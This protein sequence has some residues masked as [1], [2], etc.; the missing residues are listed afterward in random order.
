MA[1]KEKYIQRIGQLIEEAQEMIIFSK[2]PPPNVAA[3]FRIID[4]TNFSKWRNSTWNLII[5]ITGEDSHYVKSFLEQV[6]VEYSDQV[7]IGIGILKSLK[8]ELELGFLHLHENSSKSKQLDVLP[9]TE[10]FSATQAQKN[11][12]FVV[13]GHNE[14]ILFKTKDFLKKLQLEPVILRELPNEGRTI[15]EKFMEYSTQAG[16][17]IVLLTPDDRGGSKSDSYEDQKFRARQNV[18]LELGFFLG[19]LG[20]KRV[21]VLYQ[22][23]LEIPSDY[24]GVLF[25]EV[26]KTDGW[27]I[28]LAREIKKAGLNVDMNLL[29]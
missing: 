3:S 5:Q 17:A 13:H 24:Q 10:T 4:K 7:D 2:S 6:I 8:E 23:H 12:V 22:K 25:V 15:I 16:F 9:V 19:S 21:C 29:A 18:I 14:E 20:R 28:K 26:D 11:K 27:Q 1:T